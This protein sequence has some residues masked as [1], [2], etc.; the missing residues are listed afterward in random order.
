MSP[1]LRPQGSPAE[2]PP[3]RSSSPWRISP[4][5]NPREEVTS[6]VHQEV[7]RVLS[8]TIPQLLLL[9]FHRTVT[10]PHGLSDAVRVIMMDDSIFDNPDGQPLT[11]S[12]FAPFLLS[13]RLYHLPHTLPSL[14]PIL[15]FPTSLIVDIQPI[16]SVISPLPAFPIPPLQLPW[17]TFVMSNICHHPN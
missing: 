12:A 13:C 14:D 8:W 6:G 3:Y 4:L 10:W 2:S 1:L 16:S 15:S 9:T 11:G 17:V 7:Y 5:L